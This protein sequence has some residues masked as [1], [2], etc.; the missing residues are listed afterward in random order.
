ML[1]PCELLG[2]AR[3]LAERRSA[4]DGELRRS[5]S[6]SYYALFHATL[7]AAAER[8]VG[9]AEGEAPAYGL[10]YRGYSHARMK[11]ICLSIE[12]PNLAR[13][14]QQILGRRT[15]SDATRE[16]A[17]SFH[18]LQAL[19]HVADYNPQVVFRPA[20]AL[21]ACDSADRATQALARIDGAELTDILALLLVDSR[22]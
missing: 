19:R 3:E 10:L 20:D 2:L 14:Y 17:E 15:V 5:I 21:D 18:R 16:F 11:D 12:R 7:K 4:R 22:A 13:R 9:P 1:D 6:T 8:F